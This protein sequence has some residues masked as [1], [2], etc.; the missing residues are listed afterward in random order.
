MIEPIP[1]AIVLRVT[2]PEVGAE[3]DHFQ[4]RGQLADEILA[5]PMGEGAK[6][7]IDA[8][9]IDLIDFRQRRYIEMPQMQ[10]DI[11][12]L[13]RSE[14][15]KSEIQSLMRISYAVFCLKKK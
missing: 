3:I 7:D 15:H 6:D 9:E 10:E 13:L 2:Q 4:V 8:C 12:Q 14:E 1:F 11:A 5:E